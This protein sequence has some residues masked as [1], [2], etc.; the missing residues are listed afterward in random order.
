MCPDS[1]SHCAHS[2]QHTTLDH[3]RDVHRIISK[4]HQRPA[5]VRNRRLCITQARDTRCAPIAGLPPSLPQPPEVLKSSQA[6]ANAPRSS[7]VTLRGRSSKPKRTQLYPQVTYPPTHYVTTKSIR[8]SLYIFA[9]LLWLPASTM[10]TKKRVR[11]TH[12]HGVATI[13]DT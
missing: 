11:L 12:T 2:I 10:T 3:L 6:P 13:L 1:P 8:C 7:R 9:R 5:Q 4:A